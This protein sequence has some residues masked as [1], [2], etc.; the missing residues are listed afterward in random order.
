MTWQSERSENCLKVYV[1]VSPVDTS[2]ME[3]DEDDVGKAKEI[4]LQVSE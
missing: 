4:S 3:D 2:V 1:K